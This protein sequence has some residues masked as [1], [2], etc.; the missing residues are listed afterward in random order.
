MY[1]EALSRISNE[2]E[3]FTVLKINTTKYPNLKTIYNINKIP[4]YILITND[5]IV[6]KIDGYVDSFSLLRWIRKNKE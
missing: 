6:G 4:S 1:L 5:E 3:N 2:Y